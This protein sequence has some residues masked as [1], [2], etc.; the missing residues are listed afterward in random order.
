MRSKATQPEADRRLKQGALIFCPFLFAWQMLQPG[1]DQLC[2]PL[3]CCLSPWECHQCG[4][5]IRRPCLLLGCPSGPPADQPGPKVDFMYGF[6]HSAEARLWPA[7]DQKASPDE[8]RYDA[9]RQYADLR[10]CHG[11]QRGKP[12]NH[13]MYLW[14]NMLCAMRHAHAD[15]PISFRA[16]CPRVPEDCMSA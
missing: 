12:L 7:S 10:P 11:I 6:T 9:L 15:P 16:G 2:L 4:P 5:M 1:G 3:V 8:L 13:E 14:G